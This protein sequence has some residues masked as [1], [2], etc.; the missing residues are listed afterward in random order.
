MKTGMFTCGHQRLPEP[1]S[2]MQ[3]SWVTM[4]SMG[5]PP[6]RVRAG[7]KS[8]ASNKSRRWRRR[9]DADYRLH[10]R[11]HGYPYNMMLGDEHMRRESRHDQAGDRY[12]KM[13][14]GYTLIS[15][16]HAVSHAANVI[17]G[18]WQLSEL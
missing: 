11:N 6:A 3:A 9:I 16:A 12:G 13:N 2:V 8:G 15:A 5:R 10:A 1:H 14:A 18:G 17:W 4:A 7:L